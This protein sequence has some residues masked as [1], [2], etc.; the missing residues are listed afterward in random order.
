MKTI[1]NAS[2]L[3]RYVAI[4]LLA[5]LVIGPLRFMQLFQII[6]VY[7]LLISVIL[8]LSYDFMG[9]F[10]G[11]VNL[12]HIVYFGLG[13]FAF[14]ILFNLGI[15]TI[16]AAAMALVI[17]VAFA[18]GISFPMY[19]L[20]GFYFAV[21]MLGLVFLF[22][23]IMISDYVTPWLTPTHQ[24]SFGY[25]VI[26]SGYPVHESY[27]IALALAAITVL[28]SVRI[29]HSKFGLALKAIKENEQTAEV[30]GINTFRYKLLTMVLSASIAGSAGILSLWQG[31]QATAATVFSIVNAFGPVTMAMLG[32]TGTIIGPIIGSA[33]FYL[34]QQGVLFPIPAGYIGA[35]TGA[36]LVFVGLAAPGGI[37]GIVRAGLARRARILRS[38]NRQFE[39]LQT[40]QH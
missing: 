31:N 12:G 1:L 34:V 9:G 27:Y 7:Q 30:V 15:N 21:A 19:R 22:Y 37:V 40:V 17:V 18:A 32:G 5:L 23:Y 10:M 14:G 35:V 39:Y 33:L 16:L 28:V 29:R 38:G 4:A 8:A 24:L 26:N 3:S 11:Y 25:V 13:T 20:K 2:Y 36:V 6:L